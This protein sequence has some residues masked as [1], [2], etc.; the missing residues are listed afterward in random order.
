MLPSS[1]LSNEIIKINEMI[2][3][4]SC[5]GIAST[6]EKF[7]IQYYSCSWHSSRKSW[8]CSVL[9][10]MFYLCA[11]FRIT[12][13]IILRVSVLSTCGV[14]LCEVNTLYGQCVVLST[15]IVILTRPVL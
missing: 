7:N 3:K 13:A 4:V 14:L 12:L 8:L 1:Q 5:K 2:F 10:L 6:L 11:V 15:C 9:S